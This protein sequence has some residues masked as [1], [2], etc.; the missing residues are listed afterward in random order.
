MSC[1]GSE[2]PAQTMLSTC[3]A[4]L[5]PPQVNACTMLGETFYAGELLK[6]QSGTWTC[7]TLDGVSTC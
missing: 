4:A 7:T 3:M 6:D 1:P 5:L 2:D